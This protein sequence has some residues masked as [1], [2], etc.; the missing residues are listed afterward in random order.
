MGANPS[1]P[2]VS[3]VEPAAI[4]L[5]LRQGGCPSKTVLFCQSPESIAGKRKQ[6]KEGRRG[7]IFRLR[8]FS[9]HPVHPVYILSQE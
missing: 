8:R 9:F 2:P 4:V 5:L 1:G 7:K 6:K 3:G